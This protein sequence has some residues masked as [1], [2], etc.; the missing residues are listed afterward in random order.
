MQTIH[1]SAEFKTII[2]HLV[3]V[4]Q[5]DMIFCY[6]ETL[7]IVVTEQQGKTIPVFKT[8]LHAAITG[9]Q[10]PPPTCSL[11]TYTELIE[12]LENGI[13]VFSTIFNETNLVYT[14]HKKILLQ[15][16][17]IRIS[18]AK[19][20]AKSLFSIGLQR[21]LTFTTGAKQYIE[22]KDYDIAAF[23]LHQSI[24]LLLRFLL[25]S[26]SNKELKSHSL[27]ENFYQF[28]GLAPK[29]FC[30][31]LNHD[32]SEVRLLIHQLDKAYSNARY[33]S[34]FEISMDTIIE[35]TVLVTSLQKE[36]KK[37][38]EALVCPLNIKPENLSILMR[39]NGIH[40]TR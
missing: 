13:P 25:L 5:P 29:L 8:L 18:N 22:S 1:P 11:Y 3:A 35:A 14:S 2:D 37:L 23:M 30:L 4:V 21:S 28:K 39:E 38:F 17:H 32:D 19:R 26:V 31:C 34:H 20:Q 6:N 16:L 10:W 12:G 7:Y 24:E 27:K 36:A 40:A 15:P 9:H 33:S